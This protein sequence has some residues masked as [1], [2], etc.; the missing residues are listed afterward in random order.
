MS[1]LMFYCVHELTERREDGEPD[2]TF[3]E[4]ANADDMFME[5]DMEAYV[6]RAL[7]S[8]PESDRDRVEAELERVHM[9]PRLALYRHATGT[10]LRPRGQAKKGGGGDDVSSHFDRLL[11]LHDSLHDA[12]CRDDTCLEH[13]AKLVMGEDYVLPAGMTLRDVASHKAFVTVVTGWRMLDIGGREYNNVS[14]FNKDYRTEAMP[15]RDID[16]EDEDIVSTFQTV[17]RETNRT[18]D[19][20]VRRREFDGL[21]VWSTEAMKNC[22][23]KIFRVA[24]FCEMVRRLYSGKAKFMMDVEYKMAQMLFQ[25]KE[26]DRVLGNKHVIVNDALG[27]TEHR[28]NRTMLNEWTFV[29]CDASVIDGMAHP[30]EHDGRRTGTASLPGSLVQ[31]TFEG[32]HD[33]GVARYRAD[34]EHYVVPENGVLK[35]VRDHEWV[36][37]AEDPPRP[38][39]HEYYSQ[40]GVKSLAKVRTGDPGVDAHFMAMKRASDW[41][42]VNHCL[43]YDMVFVTHDKPAFLYALFMGAPAILMT[44]DNRFV[45]KGCISYAFVMY[46]PEG[47]RERLKASP[48]I[49]DPTIRKARRKRAGGDGG[50]YVC[51]VAAI[52]VILTALFG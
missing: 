16:G 50:T 26:T 40:S 36:S 6:S 19:H 11:E 20:R 38:I 41:G 31:V 23:A 5:T 29:Q 27:D 13:V 30:G 51:A 14:L 43:E 24:A 39:A 35:H 10:A 4:L 25:Y 34:S 48:P 45:K 42:Q 47:C 22:V 8:V 49:V 46:A 44:V 21:E 3:D 52:A 12:K 2:V 17:M 1:D 18:H 32:M 7:A 9:G 28:L 33:C 37:I 15:L